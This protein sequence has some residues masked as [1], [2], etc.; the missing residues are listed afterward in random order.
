MERRRL[1]WLVSLPLMAV[2]SLLA[3]SVSYRIASPGEHERVRLLAETGHAHLA[4]RPLLVAA[5][6]TLV[7]LGLVVLAFEAARGRSRPPSSS[8]SIAPFALLPLLGFVV[9]EHLERLIHD[10]S[11][12]FGAVLERPFLL[13]VLL[14]IPFALAALLLAR[15][16]TGAAYTLGRALA[17][18]PK[19]IWIPVPF[20]V[21]PTGA[22]L[23]R[24]SLL[25]LGR[26]E[27]GPPAS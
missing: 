10:N 16:L 11:F 27:R 15:I 6:L 2:T 5:L 3:H 12:P 19:A 26:A 1:A 7:L 20:S 8:F 25:A 24:I 13:G 9:Q 14:Q 22:V 23:S 18:E 21:A 17:D 4:Y